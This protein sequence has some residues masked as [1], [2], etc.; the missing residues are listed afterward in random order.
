[1]ASRTEKLS[2]PTVTSDLIREIPSIPWQVRMPMSVLMGGIVP[3]I[4]PLF[5]FFSILTAMWMDQHYS[6]FRFAM[7]SYLITCMS[8]GLVTTILVSVQLSFENHR[9]W[10]FSFFAAGGTGGYAFVYSVYWFNSYLHASLDTPLVYG[11]YF[12]YMFLVSLAVMLITGAIGVLAGLWLTRKI[13]R[14]M[15]GLS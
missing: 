4:C 7:L 6:V 10:W 13:Y 5:K 9:W 11:L 2:F 15:V 14:K 1:M 8:A 12:G 3:F